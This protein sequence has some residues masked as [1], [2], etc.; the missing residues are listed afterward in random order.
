MGIDIG[1]DRMS[2]SSPMRG[3]KRR[4]RRSRRGTE[5]RSRRSRRGRKR[6]SSYLSLRDGHQLFLVLEWP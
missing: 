6:R 4:S 3:R 2:Y 1:V 5:R